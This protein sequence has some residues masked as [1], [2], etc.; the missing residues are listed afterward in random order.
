MIAVIR[1]FRPTHRGGAIRQKPRPRPQ[2]QPKQCSMASIITVVYV[3]SLLLECMNKIEIVHPG[4]HY[5]IIGI[6]DY[7]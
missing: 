1:F 5:L 7:H 3:Y 2:K 4:H 6:T